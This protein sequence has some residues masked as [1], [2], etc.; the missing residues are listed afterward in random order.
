MQSSIDAGQEMMEE[1]HKTKI[2]ILKFQKQ[3]KEN[4]GNVK[5]IETE[6][7]SIEQELQDLEDSPQHGN[8]RFDVVTQYKNE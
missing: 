3:K 6:N 8:L 4:I 1:K 7:G 5:F 2:K